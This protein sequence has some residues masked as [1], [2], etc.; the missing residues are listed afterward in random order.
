MKT[1]TKFDIDEN[2]KN[3]AIIKYQGMIGSL[4]YLIA[5]RPDIIFSVYLCARFQTYPKKSHISIVKRIF[6]IFT[7]YN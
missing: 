4:L 5:R 6:L 2:S 7:W 1:S 3:V